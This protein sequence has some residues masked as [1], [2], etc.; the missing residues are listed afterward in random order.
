MTDDLIIRYITGRL[1][2]LKKSWSTNGFLRMKATS[3]TLS[4]LKMPGFYPDL[5]R[6]PMKPER[7]RRYRLF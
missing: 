3:A 4:G 1:I 2:S 6:K 5:T 7:I